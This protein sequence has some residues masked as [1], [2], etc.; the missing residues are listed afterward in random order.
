MQLTPFGG[1]LGNTTSGYR[2]L[3]RHLATATSPAGKTGSY[4]IHMELWFGWCNGFH[5]SFT[6]ASNA[7]VMEWGSVRK[8]DWNRW[9]V[10]G[11]WPWRGRCGKTEFMLYRQRLG[12]A[13]TVG[14]GLGK[15]IHVDEKGPALA[16][17]ALL[18]FI[19]RGPARVIWGRKANLVSCQM[20]P[21]ISDDG[22]IL[23]HNRCL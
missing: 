6:G 9:L 10:I 16:K 2:H 23:G 21:H 3:H 5:H 4:R 8:R 1:C 7:V 14:S 13:K 19:P 22:E 20:Q 18:P 17:N 11:R 12:A 15:L